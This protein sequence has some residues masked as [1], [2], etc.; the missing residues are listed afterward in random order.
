MRSQFKSGRFGEHIDSRFR[1]IIDSSA[2]KSECAPFQQNIELSLYSDLECNEK[3]VQ[4]LTSPQQWRDD[5]DTYQCLKHWPHFLCYF[6]GRVSL[7]EWEEMERWGSQTSHFPT[8]SMWSFQEEDPI[9]S[10]QHCWSKYR[11][12]TTI[13]LTFE[14]SERTLLHSTDQQPMDSLCLLIFLNNNKNKKDNSVVNRWFG[15]Y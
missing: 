12:H 8:L 11:F 14:C 6:W 5:I 2:R 13:Q 10:H 15:L 1:D 9:S 4:K 3:T 7:L